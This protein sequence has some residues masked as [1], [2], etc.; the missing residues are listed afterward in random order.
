M[1]TTNN[2]FSSVTINTIK[3]LGK[4]IWLF[5]STLGDILQII[6]GIFPHPL[7][8]FVIIMGALL[9][10]FLHIVFPYG[11]YGSEIIPS[12]IAMIVMALISIPRAFLCVRL[13]HQTKE[14]IEYYVNMV[15]F[16]K[17]ADLPQNITPRLEAAVDSTERAIWWLRN[18]LILSNKIKAPTYSCYKWCWDHPL[19]TLSIRSLCS[20]IIYGETAACI[21]PIWASVWVGVLSFTATFGWAILSLAAEATEWK[22]TCEAN[23]ERN[24][25]NSDDAESN[26]DDTNG[27][28]K[29]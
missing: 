26:D 24:N 22:K 25:V 15:S 6:C 19:A 17:E 20:A 13:Y 12:S 23:A 9:L 10:V 14:N 1:Q 8:S 18:C 29:P 3:N 7:F 4:K 21:L 11:T 2:K 27:T 16:Y 28:N 5:L